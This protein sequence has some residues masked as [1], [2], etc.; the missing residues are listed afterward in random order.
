[1]N[2]SCQ[3]E[4]PQSPSPIIVIGAGGI[5]RDAH[6]PAYRKAGFQVA[7]IVN[8]TRGKA[9][10]LAAEFGIPHVYSSIEETVAAAPENAVYDLTVMP[11]QFAG[12]L[13][14]LPEQSAVL[15]Q[16]P[17]GD[18]FGQTLE[19]LKV[20][21]R[22]RLKAGINCQLRFAPFV[23]AARDLIR[24][25]AIGEV[26]DMEVRVTVQ[27]PW[28]LF[29]NVM[30]HPRLEIQQHSVHYIDLI[31]SFLGDPHGVWARTCGHPANNFSSTRTTIA[32]DYGDKLRATIAVNHDHR[33]G[34]RHQESFIKW[35]GTNGA[36]KAQFGLLKDYPV[37]DEDRFEYCLLSDDREPSWIHV[38]IE[39]TWFPD[40]FIGS[41]AA[42]MRF[43]EGSA[44]SLP[45]S[46]EDV[47]RTMACV[48]AAYTSSAQGATPIPSIPVGMETAS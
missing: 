16:K 33:F 42:V 28:E 21:R 30:H 25:G 31:R 3:P 19:I 41:M 29:P 12:I 23:L 5:V 6:L 40:A 27:T 24:R 20:C 9:E 32:F 43:A 44:A 13:E 15:I 37:G 34:P 18:D 45:T 22:R 48:E 46:V 26:Y 2:I 17:M 8:R 7:G 47:A 38:P 39:G 10:Q 4:L 11:L 35:E 14:A 1:M 36:I